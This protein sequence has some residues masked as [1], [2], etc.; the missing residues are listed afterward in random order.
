MSKDDTT[1]MRDLRSFGKNTIVL[2]AHEESSPSATSSQTRNPLQPINI[3]LLDNSNSLFTGD[4][5]P[6]IKNE[7]PQEIGMPQNRSGS[8]S[9]HPSVLEAP[10]RESVK[11]EPQ[12]DTPMPDAEPSNPASNQSN[13]N[14][15]L[16]K[17]IQEAS[18]EALEKE[19]RSSQIFL[20][21]LRQPLQAKSDLSEDAKHWF[22]Q[23][24]NLQRHVV[25]T[26]TIIGVVGNTGA[27]KSSVINAM[28]DEERLVP[29]NCS[30]YSSTW[31]VHNSKM[32]Q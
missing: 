29:T 26:P 21:S 13:Q 9:Q 18:P 30:K 24:S 5:K 15:R 12:V 22:T 7:Q 1:Q 20:E 25:N 3:Q 31:I 4:T 14:N 6:L 19:V 2:T 11:A 10:A 16:Q 23:I 27:G 32:R 17:L 8:S 28:L